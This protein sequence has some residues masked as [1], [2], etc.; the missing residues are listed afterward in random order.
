MNITIHC[1]YCRKDKHITDHRGSWPKRCRDEAC[2]QAHNRAYIKA[3]RANPQPIKA[4]R[5]R[6]S[7][8]RLTTFYIVSDPDT[9]IGFLSGARINAVEATLEL[10]CFS[11]NTILKQAG[12]HFRVT[13]EIG[14]N[15]TLQEIP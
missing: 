11:P 8:E 10:G 15:Q 14:S 6:K 13:G 4:H 9:E 7:G 1:P 5:K 2:R 3:R 12:H